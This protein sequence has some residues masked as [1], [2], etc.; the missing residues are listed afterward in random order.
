MSEATLTPR[1][2]LVLD[3]LQ[4]YGLRADFNR[5]RR[6]ETIL[7]AHALGIPVRTIAEH[8][9]LSWSQVARIARRDGDR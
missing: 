4:V 7:Q 6:N 9:G 3:Q 1:Q 8:A 5:V 2:Q